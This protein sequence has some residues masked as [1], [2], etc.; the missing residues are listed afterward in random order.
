MEYRPSSIA[1][2]I[3]DQFPKIYREDG[4]DFIEFVKAYY[5]YLD[6]TSERN[7]SALGDIDN[8]LERFLKHYK[9][10]YLNGLP[11]P[12]SSTQDIPFIVKN[13]ADLYRSKGTQEALELMFRMFY[14]QEIEVYYPASS[15][16]TLSDSKWAFSTY[17]EFKPISNTATFPVQRG[18][19]IEGDSSK[20]TAF[21]DEIVFY[22]IDGVQVPVGYISNVYG[23]FN[24]DD[25]LKVTRAGVDSF[26]GKLI[27]GSIAKPEAL[28]KDGIVASA[29][30]KRLSSSNGNKWSVFIS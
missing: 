19:I 15:I 26:P 22:N 10:K 11:F 20:A 27:Y 12:E 21:V 5:E 13:I 8:T 3:P 28:D 25:A 7:F 30:P 16:L 18:D 4:P 24:S 9:N 29:H 1:S 17:L 14:K 2:H 23:K 6:N